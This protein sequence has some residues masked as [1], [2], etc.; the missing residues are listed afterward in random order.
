MLTHVEWSIGMLTG[1][2]L[3]P[4]DCPGT[5]VIFRTPPGEVRIAWLSET[6]ALL[7]RVLSFC[8]S[9]IPGSFGQLDAAPLKRCKV[10][11]YRIHFW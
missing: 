4:V 6:V 11:G 5:A 2:Y 3:E 7:D 9:P 10:V 1:V 8:G